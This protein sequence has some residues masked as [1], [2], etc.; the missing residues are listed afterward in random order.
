MAKLPESNRPGVPAR[1]AYPAPGYQENSRPS[2]G[3]CFP[4]GG[5]ANI[6][7]PCVKP[8]HPAT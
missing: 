5:F 7:A 2:W 6:A 8:H 4:L 1:P 3:D